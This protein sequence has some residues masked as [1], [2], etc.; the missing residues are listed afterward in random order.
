MSSQAVDL[1]VCGKSLSSVY[2]HLFVCC[3]Y[4]ISVTVMFTCCVNLFRITLYVWISEHLKNHITSA[5]DV[6]DSLQWSNHCC[7]LHERSSHKFIWSALSN[8]LS[9]AILY[10]LLIWACRICLTNSFIDSCM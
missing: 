4:C 6:K 1:I 3:S 2:L 5:A 10:I 7:R 8:F 9:F